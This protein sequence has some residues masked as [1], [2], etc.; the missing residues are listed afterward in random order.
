VRSR[1]KKY[2][3][4]NASVMFTEAASG[5]DIFSAAHNCANIENER[6]KLGITQPSNADTMDEL[7]TLN[8]G[9]ARC[10]F[11]ID[12]TAYADIDIKSLSP[13]RALRTPLDPS[14]QAAITAPRTQPL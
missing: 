4:D 11:D 7:R 2:F 14:G 12:I 3:I 1:T 5:E 8:R 13:G 6:M 10:G 9:V